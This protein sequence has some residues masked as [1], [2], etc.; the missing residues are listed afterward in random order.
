MQ[1][2]ET[3]SQPQRGGL[4][5]PGEAAFLAG[6]QANFDGALRTANPYT[7]GNVAESWAAG[8]KAAQAVR[9]EWESDNYARCSAAA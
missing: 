2:N 5:T 3:H 9:D 6:E 8:W 7:G 1:A 4:V